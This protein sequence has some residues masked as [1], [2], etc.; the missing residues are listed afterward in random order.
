MRPQRSHFLRLAKELFSRHRWLAVQTPLLDLIS[1]L[2]AGLSTWLLSSVFRN[3]AG[4][5]GLLLAGMAAG[6]FAV[7]I[8]TQFLAFTSTTRLWREFEAAASIKV[9]ERLAEMPAKAALRLPFAM[10]RANAIQ[11][12][13]KDV[14]MAA[15]ACRQIA[16]IPSSLLMLIAA[17]AATVWLDP[18]LPLF[19][20]TAVALAMPV[21][22]MVNRKAV[23][24]SERFEADAS[25]MAQ[26]KAEWLDR[27]T[28]EAAAPKSIRL[29][30][31]ERLLNTFA[32]RTNLIAES[33]AIVMMAGTV[34]LIGSLF[35][36]SREPQAAGSYGAGM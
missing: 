23:R 22:Y 35:Y 31:T 16:Q 28:N 11:L 7:S 27:Q 17:V 13:Q 5:D 33:S 14:R 32:D 25:A 10:T 4:E 34:S 30:S 29:P 26:E 19:P 2:A 6:A 3:G 1:I 9:M 15:L 21:L 36:L 24:L 18:L 20:L 8:G 12:I